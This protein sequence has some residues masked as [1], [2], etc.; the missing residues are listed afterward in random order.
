MRWPTVVSYACAVLLL[1]LFF[2]YLTL[3]IQ[4]ISRWLLHQAEAVSGMRISA[5]SVQRLHPLGLQWQGVS[6]IDPSGR[7]EWITFSALSVRPVFGSLLSRRKVVHVDGEFANGVVEGIVGVE[8]SAEGPH[9]QIDLTQ[10]EGL[11]MSRFQPFLPTVKG[12]GGMI[13]GNMS[14][15]W[16]AAQPLFGSGTLFVNIDKLTLQGGTVRGF[17]IGEMRFDRATCGVAVSKG[18][19][20]ISN[21]MAQGPMGRVTVTGSLQLQAPVRR[22][23]LSLRV[24]LDLQA[25]SSVTG[26][27]LIV[28]ITGPLGN[29][30]IN[31][32]GGFSLSGLEGRFRKGHAT[33]F[34]PETA[35]RSGSDL[36]QSRHG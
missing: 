34:M 21:C 3:P 36:I 22:T 18:R 1:F 10:V 20:A 24:E 15:E 8:S 25:L 12:L 17:P 31:I 29:P 2:L 6:L 5:V 35:A 14:Y 9:Y 11:S 26:Q 16:S 28:V 32:E 27:P 4:A 7:Q 23:F 19:A 30:Q 33:D 13:S